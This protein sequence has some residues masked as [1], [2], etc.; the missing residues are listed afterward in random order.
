MI[1]IYSALITDFTQADY[2]NAYSLL[3][4]ALKEKIDAKKKRKR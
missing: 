1:K 2:T 4:N 3:E